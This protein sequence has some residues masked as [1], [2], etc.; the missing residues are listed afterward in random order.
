MT[1]DPFKKV[2][3]G[4]KLAIPALAYNAF[5]DAALST[6]TTQ[7]GM[8]AT[9]AKT[10]WRGDWLPVYNNS[11]IDA[12]QFSILK[13]V[14]PI[15]DPVGESSGV[16]DQDTAGFMQRLAIEATPS[17]T[18]SGSEGLLCI[19]TQAIPQGK[20]GR[21]WV[22]GLAIGLAEFDEGKGDLMRVI[23]KIPGSAGSVYF[24]GDETGET[25]VLWRGGDFEDK[26][27]VIVRLGSDPARAELYPVYV[28]KDGGSVGNETTQCSVT[29]TV[30]DFATEES[31]ATGKTPEKARPALGMLDVADDLANKRVGWAYNTSGTFKLWD[32]NETLEVES[33]EADG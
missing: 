25:Q 30:L 29:Y 12:D 19:A 33:C 20:I 9:D 2:K 27:W 18:A 23:P 24:E 8:F 15:I 31:V 13:I 17:F 7:T 5:I 10:R 28:Y 22:D 6:Q 1:T 11:S 26:E 3:T 21:A 4:D 32:A 16:P 14:G